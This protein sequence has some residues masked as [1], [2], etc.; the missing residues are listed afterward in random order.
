[1]SA[2]A[3]FSSEAMLCKT[4][5]RH[6]PAGWTAYPESGGWDIVLVR[7]D[8]LQIG[9]EA[10]LTLNAK[11]ITQ[12]AEE[13][14]GG[15]YAMQEGPDFRAVLIPYGTAGTMGWLCHYLGLTVIE[16]M[17]KA[18]FE[19]SDRYYQ[20]NTTGFTPHLPAA[21]G[22][23]W[24]SEDHWYDMAPAKRITLPD[25]VPD[26][27]AG[28]S[29]PTKLTDWKIKAI[30]IAVSVERR[31]F[32]TRADFKHV[33]IDHRRWLNNAYGWLVVGATRGIYIAGPRLGDFKAQH[34]KNFE[35]IAADYDKWR[36]PDEVPDA[37]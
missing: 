6:L 15:Y 19:S 17:D 8:G 13:G 28:R 29:G 25:Y 33:G 21:T 35:Q 18:T 24:F 4:F 31:G 10:K 27:T 11:I 20:R 32:V 1:M 30:K 14:R 9:I 23:G 37:A 22:P 16:M 5:I 12:A 3:K 7:D 26:V 2:K 34:P 36:L